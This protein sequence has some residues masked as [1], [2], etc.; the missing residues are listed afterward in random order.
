MNALKRTLGPAAIALAISLGIA[1]VVLAVSG[2]NPLTA[3]KAMWTNAASV[4]GFITILNFTSRYYVSGLAVAIG[5]KINLFNI[6]VNGQYT[7]AALI[8]GAYGA[9]VHLPAPLHVASILVVAMAV[10]AM[11]AAVPAL[12]KMYRNVHEVVAT[13][14]LNSVA[15]GIIAYLLQSKWTHFRDPAE[16]QLATTRTIPP[17]GRL[18]GINIG[19][20]RLQTFVFIAALIGIAFYVLV[21]R[22][23]FGFDL[24]ASGT[25]PAAARSSGVNPKRMILITMLLSG[26]MA[27]MIGMGVLIG[28][29]EQL[30]YGDRFPTQ[31]GLTGI[32][33]ALLGR[34]HPG[35]VLFAAFT[36]SAIEQGARGLNG[37]GVPSEIGSILLGT[38]LLVA[39]II[40]TVWERR[41]QEATIKAAAARTHQQHH[42]HTHD[43]ASGVTA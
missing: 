15:T 10:G 14:M 13:I 33:I 28:Q 17:S 26:A 7:L 19:T 5:F 42:Q 41:S 4:N 23:R 3:Y 34:N 27:G 36:W 21:Y 39:V 35:G 6:G 8:A 2:H 16:Q 22:T 31:L 20:S 18:P 1:A 11:W 40:Y 30:T 9:A 37:V 38:L 12:L 32:G 24:R 29:G 43:Q 25:N